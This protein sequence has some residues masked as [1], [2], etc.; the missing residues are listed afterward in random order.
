MSKNKIDLF[1][2][3]I[4]KALS[5]ALDIPIEQLEKEYEKEKKRKA[6]VNGRVC[7]TQKSLL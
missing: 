7:K 3:E 5:K 1:I 2:T 6:D 4:K